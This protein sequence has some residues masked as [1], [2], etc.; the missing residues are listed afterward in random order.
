MARRS[1]TVMLLIALSAIFALSR[2]V[3]AETLSTIGV[4]WGTQMTHPIPP[5]I[6]VDM[7]KANGIKKVKLFDAD[8]WT[9]SA[10][11]GTDIEVM[12]G[13]PNAQLDRIS[14]K[15]SH[16]KDWVKNN[17]TQYFKDGGVN[18]KYVAVGNE[19]FLE[20]Y[21]GS[22]LT[23]T[24]PALQNIQKALDEAG[25]G[26]KIKVTVPLNADVYASSSNTPSSGAFRSDIEDLMN[27]I[28][29]FLKEKG[30]AFVVNIYPFLSL[31]QNA[32][33]PVDYAFFGTGSRGINDNGKQYTNVFDAN[34][35]TL[36]W[37]LKKAG[38]P[39]LKIIVG[40]VGWP[41]DGDKNANNDMAKKFYDGLLKKMAKKVGTPMRPGPVDVYL[42]GLIDEDSKS[43]LPGNFER[44]WGILTYDGKP[45]F[46]MDLSG[47]GNDKY[48]IAAKGIQYL[49]AQWCVFNN[50]AKNLS[51]LSA[52]ID[53]ACSLGDCTSLGYGSSC[54]NLNSEGNISYAFN[55]YFQM[56]DQDVRAC[57][58]RGLAKI[59]DRN[60][61][62][63]DCL[64]PVQ[65]ISAGTRTAVAK[66]MF[67][68]LLAALLFV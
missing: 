12:V 10:L 13:I 26:D 45:K 58:F 68:G 59:V 53:Y 1:Q 37:A 18:I 46:P 9:M 47:L 2:M 5:T 34:F 67:L 14:S 7:L 17:V 6:V 16:A 62:Q 21:N 43:I 63:K 23:T 54:N 40:E 32:G 44:H 28:V 20:S 60:A 4:N 3:N 57:D 29:H 22:Y 49:P 8:D 25:H 51:S 64:F 48:L 41:T 31:Y 24:F 27:Q 61:S 52:D 19:P 38:V 30:S 56:S 36:A 55:M 35:D 11:V 39:D 66:A 33:F 42:F 15:Y 50:E 65:I